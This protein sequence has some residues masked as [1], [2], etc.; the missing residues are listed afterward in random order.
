MANS[1]FLFTDP[2]HTIHAFET[3][4]RALP[5]TLIV[6]ISTVLFS[7]VVALGFTA[8]KIQQVPIVGKIIAVWI[9]FLRGTPVLVQ[10]YLSF[11]GVPALLE[12]AGINANSWSPYI[13]PIIALVLHGSA[14]LSEIM[15][16]AWLGVEKGQIEAAY[17]I[18]LGGGQMFRRILFPQAFKIAL[19]NLGNYIIDILKESSLVFSVGLLDIMGRTKMLSQSEYG[20]Y[21][22]E[23]FIIVAF[24][25]WVM[26]FTV[27]RV[28]LLAE[29]RYGRGQAN[30]GT[31]KG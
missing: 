28:F 31:E 1:A 17:S 16:S 18:G 21:Q 25:Y 24:I 2:E 15:R 30:I 11:Y 5:V 3:I 8:V 26:C 13:F 6:T 20:I 22:L 29:K 9:S 14:F 10:L 4:L 27:E 12:S 23:N 7:F 19:P